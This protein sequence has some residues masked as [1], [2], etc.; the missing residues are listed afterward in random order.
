MN[1]EHDE[2][3]FDWIS[4]EFKPRAPYVKRTLS[5]KEAM[6]KAQA[7]QQLR[8]RNAKRADPFNPRLSRRLRDSGMRSTLDDEWQSQARAAFFVFQVSGVERFITEDFRKWW[9]ERGDFRKPR[10]H[11]AWGAFTHAL[12]R[13][14]LIR[15]TGDVKAAASVKSHAR[16]MLEWEVV[17]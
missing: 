16:K 7:Q 9:I 6:D 12:R 1:A 11:N 13:A 8:E 10:H 15:P 2:E 14:G 3:Q 5:S 4:G 17:R